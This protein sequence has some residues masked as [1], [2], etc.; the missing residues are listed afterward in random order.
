MEAHGPPVTYLRRIWF[1]GHREAVSALHA[2]AMLDQR[3]VEATLATRRREIRTHECD[4][5]RGFVLTS[6]AAQL[7][8]VRENKCLAPRLNRR[9]ASPKTQCRTGPN[10]AEPI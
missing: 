4:V 10:R 9:K 2:A 5:C 3:A 1:R 7:G 6:V 8:I